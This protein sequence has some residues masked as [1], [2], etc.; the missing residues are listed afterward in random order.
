MLVRAPPPC[1]GVPCLCVAPPS[2][3]RA[4][5]A[6]SAFG[7]WCCSRLDARL[8]LLVCCCLRLRTACVVGCWWFVVFSWPGQTGQPPERVRCANPCFF[9]AGVIALPLVFPCTL[10]SVR[11]LA[12]RWCL[13]PPAAVPP[14][15]TPP[16]PSACC[17]LPPPL[18]LGVPRPPTVVPAPPPGGMPF[19]AA[20]VLLRVYPCC[21]CALWLL[22]AAWPFVGASCCPPPPPLLP[23]GLCFLGVGPCRSFSFV[24]LLLPCFFRAC[25]LGTCLVGFLF[26]PSA[27]D[28]AA[29]P[30]PPPPGG[31]SWWCAVPRILFCGAAVGCGLFCAARGVLL[32]RAVLLCGCLVVWCARL[33][34][35]WSSPV[36][37]GHAL[38]VGVARCSASPCCF[39]RCFAVCGA[40]VCCP[41]LWC[42]PCCCVVSW[43]FSLCLLGSAHLRICA[44]WCCPNPPP[45]GL[46]VVPSAGLC[47]RGVLACS[48][49]CGYVLLLALL[50]CSR[51]GVPCRVLLCSA[52]GV[53]LRCISPCGCALLRAL[54]CPVALCCVVVRSAVRWGAASWCSVLCCPAVCSCGLLC[55]VGRW[56]CAV[57]CVLCCAVGCCCVLCCAFGRGVWLRCA[58]LSSLWLAVL[59]WSRCSVLCCASWCC[60]GPCRVVLCCVVLCCCAL[61]CGGGTVLRCLVVCGAPS[62]C[63]VPSG[64][65]RCLGCC[66]LCCVL[67]CAAMFCAVP[68]GVVS[69]CAVLCCSR[70]VLLFG[71]GLCSCVVCCVSWCCGA[72]RCVLFFRAVLCC[73]ALC[74]LRGAVLF[75]L[76]L[77]GAVACCA[78][79]PGV[80]LR[81]GVLCRLVR[82]FAVLPCAVRAALCV[83]CR[84]VLVCA[85][86]AVVRCTAGALWCYLRA[87]SKPEKTASYFQKQKKLFPAGLPRVPCP[88]CMQQY[89]TLKKTTL[90]FLFNSWPWAGVHRRSRS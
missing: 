81:C 38:S 42:F 21:L 3:G 69:W 48:A 18:L 1:W 25:G 28:G 2:V 14:P 86:F 80:V 67:C 54:P 79:P 35:R 17:L 7:A 60:V 57:G 74:C 77:F 13:S 30:P 4:V 24:L 47:C 11:F 65:V 53:V 49:L 61:C 76:A 75:L 29:P 50:W 85:V 33:L 31:C 10:V 56:R 82:C 41:V 27:R 51:C 71:R 34:Y 37:V 89:H 19:A 88:P 12:L 84:C 22:C 90:L 15:H 87:F 44:A 63:D 45:P 9:F 58:A 40:V 43:L 72:L 20:G 70:C 55:A 73:C 78:L 59:F 36:G 52:G 46:C 66:V 16:C 6:C 26:P 23:P 32:R 8:V 62:C 39:V 83:F 64:A 5:L 68:G